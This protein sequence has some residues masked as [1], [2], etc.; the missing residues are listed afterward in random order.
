MNMITC[1]ENSLNKDN[2]YCSLFVIEPLNLGHGITL[3]TALRRILLSEIRGLSISAV[4][5]AGAPHEYADLEYIRE[6]T[7]ELLLNLKKIVFKSTNSIL[8]L[9]IKGTIKCTGPK[10]VTANS[11][12]TNNENLLILNPSQY[13]CSITKL[14]K[15][16]LKLFLEEGQGYKSAKD[17]STKFATN[18]NENQGSYI[19]TDKNYNPIKRV[20]YKL[21]LIHD[22][23][24]LLKESLMIEIH[25]NGCVTPLKAIK[26]SAQILLDLF[27]P[28][29]Y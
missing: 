20:N 4:Q 21:F 28:L 13:I 11:L 10:I 8:K 1:V 22:K 15:L 9:P 27:Y 7:I 26:K 5:I 23:N 17:F 16:N 2:E 18:L 14:E 24:G 3:G 29:T 12:L 6:N 19:F 25:T